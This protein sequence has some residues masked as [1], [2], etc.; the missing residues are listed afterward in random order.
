MISSDGVLLSGY[1]TFARWN[2]DEES[3]SLGLGFEVV[4]AHTRWSVSLSLSSPPLLPGGQHLHVHGTGTIRLAPLAGVPWQGR[5]VP[6]LSLA[7]TG[8]GTWPEQ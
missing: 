4:K 8:S 6:R 5:R 3:M 2:L 1:G 7:Q